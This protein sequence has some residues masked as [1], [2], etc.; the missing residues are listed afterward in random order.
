MCAA[1]SA[2]SV[3][4]IS[5][6]CLRSRTRPHRRCGTMPPARV[7][8]DLWKCERLGHA[9]ARR[10]INGPNVDDGSGIEVFDEL[11][12]SDLACAYTDGQRPE[13]DARRPASHLIAFPSVMWR[14][15]NVS[16]A[17]ASFHPIPPTYITHE[18][19]KVTKL[20]IG[21]LRVLEL[22]GGVLEKSLLLRVAIRAGLG[23]GAVVHADLCLP[24]HRWLRRGGA[25][26]HRKHKGGGAHAA[27]W[28]RLG[29][30][31]LSGRRRF[32]P[33]STFLIAGNEGK[34]CRASRRREL[35][36]AR[37]QL[38]RAARSTGSGLI[39]DQRLIANIGCPRSTRSARVRGGGNSD[40]P[41][42]DRELPA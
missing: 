37:N 36:A 33:P 2:A 4:E 39:D 13:R 10:H 34:A 20:N 26:F 29:R 7:D 9:R 32:G 24:R 42:R 40:I 18:G 1:R 8:A 15:A 27:S 35:R 14:L 22:R 19:T 25:R 17:L 11:R 23:A 31:I 3:R 6:L 16:G 41:D 28:V 38:K 21:F 12:V 30:P 5:A